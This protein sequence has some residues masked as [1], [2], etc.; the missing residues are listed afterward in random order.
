[1]GM[2]DDINEIIKN[3][4]SINGNGWV[5]RKNISSLNLEN[6]YGVATSDE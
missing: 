5:K 4:F 2:F 1:M 3:L 6:C